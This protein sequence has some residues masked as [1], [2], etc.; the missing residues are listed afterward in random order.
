MLH[1]FH[2]EIHAVGGEQLV[3]KSHPRLIVG[4]LHFIF[5]LRSTSFQC[6]LFDNIFAEDS[7]L[8]IVCN[9]PF[10]SIVGKMIFEKKK[11]SKLVLPVHNVLFWAVG[12]PCGILANRSDQDSNVETVFSIKVH[13]YPDLFTTM[14]RKNDQDDVRRHSQHQNLTTISNNIFKAIFPMFF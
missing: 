6:I 5:T 11:T 2:R 14:N 3:L 13:N 7:L 9:C 1:C 4:Y 10:L 8:L 12:W